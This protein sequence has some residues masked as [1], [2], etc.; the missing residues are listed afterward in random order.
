[1]VRGVLRFHQLGPVVAE[2]HIGWVA[3]FLT[4]V[5]LSGNEFSNLASTNAESTQLHILL[6][7]AIS[8]G[9]VVSFALHEAIRV[10]TTRIACSRRQ[11]IEF[12]PVG[13]I[14]GDL[15]VPRSQRH[16][17]YVAL[18]GML[19]TGAAALGC[20]AL[21]LATDIEGA[22]RQL[23]L[24]LL[25]TNAVLFL[26]NMLPAHPFDGGRILRALFWYL[27]SSYLSGVRV[28]FF[29]SHLLGAT[30]L[31]YGV[32]LLSWRDDLIVPGLW[33][34][35]GGWS[36]TRAARNDLERASVISGSRS[37]MAEDAVR[38]FNPTIRASDSLLDAV[39]TL[40]DQT[41]HGP[42]LVRDGTEFVGILTLPVVRRV[43]RS[44]WSQYAA[45]DVAIPL[46]AIPASNPGDQLVSAVRLLRS[47]NS[48]WVLVTDTRGQV[49]GAID[50][51]NRIAD[52][53]RRAAESAVD[54]PR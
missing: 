4:L 9:I 53:V 48:P 7:T 42:G 27:H 2:G 5:V 31:G 18:C 13:S 41:G 33:L 51:S 22:A 40:L 28:L 17:V 35:A 45:R 11:W 44:R 21:Y 6:V 32:F 24:A 49:I 1:L 47:S 26:A 8:L 15:D 16:E 10:V 34:V 39:D 23:V 19:V 37:L 43:P 14:P 52:L 20:G 29:V 30:A 50:H 54:A 12:Y 3:T 36:I 38:G 25:V 46:D